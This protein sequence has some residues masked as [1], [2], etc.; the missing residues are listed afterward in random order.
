MGQI[1]KLIAII[2]SGNSDNNIKFNDLKRLLIR[3]GF[4]ERI[5]GS[6]HIFRKNEVSTM[7]N[8]QSDGDMAKSY[9]VKQ[10][11]NLIIENNLWI[12]NE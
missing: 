9:Q 10:I 5:K 7:I 2:L 12:E 6:H 4:T 11:R 1:E 3:L 8:L